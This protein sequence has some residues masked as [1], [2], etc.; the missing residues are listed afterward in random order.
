MAASSSRSG[1][2]TRV[3]I[4][5]V[6]SRQLIR[7][8]AAKKDAEAEVQARI[9]EAREKA[10]FRIAHG[11]TKEEYES[12]L[13]EAFRCAAFGVLVCWCS[14]WCS[15]FVFVCLGVC[16]FASGAAGLP[17]PALRCS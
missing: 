17:T 6:P 4:V 13:A 12:I 7:S 11:I 10:E 14:C 3:Q 9:N 15:C 1:C 2:G 8:F 5:R 16:W